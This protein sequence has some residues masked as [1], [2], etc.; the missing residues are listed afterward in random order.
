MKDHDFELVLCWLSHPA[1]VIKEASYITATGT[2][3]AKSEPLSIDRSGTKASLDIILE[4]YTFN[5]PK[6][7]NIVYEFTTSPNAK[8]MFQAT[9]VANTISFLNHDHITY[10]PG[11]MTVTV[12]VKSD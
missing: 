5:D 4:P 10:A 2:K 7:G 11:K 12:D 3:E 9:D 1:T 6:C 8:S